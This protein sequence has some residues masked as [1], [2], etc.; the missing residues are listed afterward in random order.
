MSFREK[1]AWISLGVT[2]LVWGSY[3]AGVWRELAGPDPSGADILGLFVGAVVLTVV[4]EV[5]LAIAA[6]VLSPKSANSPADERER[7]IELRSTRIAYAILSVGAV[8]VALA[9][10]LL[11]AR[12]PHLLGDPLDDAVLITANGV[13]VAL[14]AAEVVKWTAQVIAFRR[15]G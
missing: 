6:A 7:M 4:L 12:G 3:F 8:T 9:S 14:I 11:A 2:A 1:T 5:A 13:L 15:G 10:P